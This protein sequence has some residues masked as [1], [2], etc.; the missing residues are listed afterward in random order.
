MVTKKKLEVELQFFGNSN[1]IESFPGGYS[2]GV[3]SPR[4]GKNLTFLVHRQLPDEDGILNPVQN[5]GTV[6]GSFQ[7]NLY[8][9]SQGYRELGTYLLALAE[10]DTTADDGFHQH[11][12]NVKSSDGRTHAHIILRKSDRIPRSARRK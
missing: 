3:P 9:N 8:G 2:G 11:H 12:D 7:I 5:E 6:E 10:L 1:A 4:L